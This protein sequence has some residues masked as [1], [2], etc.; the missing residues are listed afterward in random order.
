MKLIF[1]SGSN[2]EGITMKVKK[3]NHGWEGF[4][5]LGDEVKVRIESGPVRL[6]GFEKKY[7]LCICILGMM[8]LL[9]EKKRNDLDLI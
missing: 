2:S 4:K 9:R 7:M 1:W 6:N 3:I 5:I 8:F